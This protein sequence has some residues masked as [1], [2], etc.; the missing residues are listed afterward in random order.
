[1]TRHFLG[2][3]RPSLVTATSAVSLRLLPALIAAHFRFWP[4]APVSGRA[5]HGCYRE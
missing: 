3:P 4:I 2:L 1:M 5:Q